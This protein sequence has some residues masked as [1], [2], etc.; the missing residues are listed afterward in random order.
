[1]I[2]REQLAAYL[3]DFLRTDGFE[4]YGPNGLQVEGRARIRRVVS[5][6]TASLA[7]IERAAQQG[8]DAILV[9]HGWF[10]RG[11]DPR[12][13]GQ[14]RK[15]L[16][17]LMAADLNLFAYHLPLDAHP[18]VGNNAQLAARMGW[19]A[20]GRFG[21]QDLGWLGSAPA[22]ETLADLAAELGRKLERAPVLV[23]DPTARVGRLAWCTGAA[24]GWVEQ[25][26]AAGANTYIS[27]EISEPTAHF[28][29][30]MGIA[31][32]AGG[33]HA[34]ERYGVQ[35]LGGHLERSF[36]IEHRFIDIDNPA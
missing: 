28:A 8:A 25:A 22:Q 17:A 36:G 9:H 3:R 30:E 31:Y 18:L 15:R 11:E 34:T 1:M 19:R 20:D 2:D 12:V 21:K 10:W 5:G 32:L 27:G 6:V 4:D 33:H 26:H 16:A 7:L 14:K 29:R 13:V 35:A 24:Q 23:G